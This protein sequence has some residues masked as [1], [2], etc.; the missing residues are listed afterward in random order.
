MGKFNCNNWSNV[1]E[2]VLNN[3]ESNDEKTTQ[4]LKNTYYNFILDL[5]DGVPF[6]HTKKS[7]YSVNDAVHIYVDKKMEC[8]FCLYVLPLNLTL[9]MSFNQFSKDGVFNDDKLIELVKMAYKFGKLRRE[10]QDVFMNF[11]NGIDE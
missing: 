11:L 1:N 9:S 3:V 2:W 5:R 10:E 8:D 7:M 4:M 6:T